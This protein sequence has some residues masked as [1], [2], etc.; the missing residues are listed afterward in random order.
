M[1]VLVVHNRYQSSM[2]SGENRVV[3][4]EVEGLRAAGHEVL[5]YLRS[6]D[7]LGGLSAR[8]KAGLVVSP[9]HSRRAVADVTRLLDTGRPDVLHLHNPYPLVS[10]GV[11][12][13]AARAGVPV[14]QTV[15]NH[16][17]TCMKGTYVRGGEPCHQC[18]T[19]RQPLP[20]V[21]HGCYRD[22]RAQS[23]VM[24]VALLRARPAYAQIS[25]LIALTPEIRDSLLAS[26]FDSARIVIKPNSVPD[27]GPAGPAGAGFL[28]IG[29]LSEEKGV[30]ALAE[31]W[32][33]HPVGALGR[34]RVAGDGPVRDRLEALVRGRD[35][36]EVLGQVDPARVRGL[37]EETAAV[38]VPSQWPE[39]FPLVVLEAMAS[40][41]ALLV[42][43]QGGLPAVVDPEV[44]RVV[45]ATVEGLE[46]GL[47]ELAGDPGLTARLGRSARARYEAAYSPDVVIGR[48]V[49]V[50]RDA[51]AGSAGRAAW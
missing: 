8:E 6:S 36:I 7:E 29:R 31:A 17:H 20:G 33:R 42:T 47:R 45:P 22:S 41:R 21:V 40:G 35:D 28:Y 23:A 12:S 25:R 4:I 18:R 43:D 46:A 9:V 50:Y 51:G 24:A 5:T 1:R 27:P 16:R 37:L 26:G 19:A 38:V 15:H 48:L 11:V 34:L 14:V 13:A 2:P 3:D 32:T 44:G 30:L 39:A 49:E 10:M